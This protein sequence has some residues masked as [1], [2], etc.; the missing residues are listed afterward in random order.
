VKQRYLDR[1]LENGGIEE[2]DEEEGEINS[3]NRNKSSDDESDREEVGDE[4]GRARTHAQSAPRPTNQP[5]REQ[6][7]RQRKS[8]K[9]P[10]VF[11][12]SPMFKEAHQFLS[13]D[14]FLT[15]DEKE[16]R[17]DAASIRVYHFLSR[18]PVDEDSEHEFKSIQGAHHP[19]QTI[20]EYCKVRLHSPY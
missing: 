20:S 8:S 14:H 18:L 4:R 3:I 15:I 13:E 11:A 12:E 19:V 2:A 10:A 16:D 6:K 7:E 1:L 5:K 9:S 17:T